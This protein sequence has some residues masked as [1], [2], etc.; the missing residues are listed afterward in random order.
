MEKRIA[1]IGCGTIG[2]ELA[3]SI[4][5]GLVSNCSLSMIFD[6]DFQRIQTTSDRLK[7]K[8]MQFNNFKDFVNSPQFEKIDLVIEAASINAILEYGLDVLKRGK[9]IMIMSIGAFS[10]INFYQNILEIIESRSNN[11]YLPSGAI[12]GI[13]LIRSVRKHLESVTLTTTKNNKSL[14]GAPF[15]LNNNIDVEKITMKQVLFEGNALDAIKG[16]PAN[17]NVAAI[18]SIAGMGFDKTSVRIVIDPMEKNNRHE[19]DVKWKFGQFKVQISNYPSLQN[20]KT[21]YLASL[22]AI[23]CLRAICEHKIIIGS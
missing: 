11:I 8:P 5:S 21:S 19:I 12:G 16:F 6:V 7:K 20:P 15:F 22:S 10:N 13:D 17:V 23:E 2:N 9:D 18:I 4:D 14:K 1:I 3:S